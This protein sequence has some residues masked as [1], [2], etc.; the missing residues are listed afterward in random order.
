MSKEHFASSLI[1]SIVG[2]TIL[3]SRGYPTVEVEVTTGDGVFRASCPSE[4]TLKHEAIALRDG[5]QQRWAGKTVD[6]A[7]DMLKTTILHPL[8]G[9]SVSDQSAVD[10]LL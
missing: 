8:I 9:M 2:R 4:T 10:A 5:D 6:K 1:K 7:L 3:D